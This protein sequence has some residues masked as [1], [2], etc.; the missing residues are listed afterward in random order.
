MPVAG[1]DEFRFR[2]EHDGIPAGCCSQH[3]RNARD[4]ARTPDARGWRHLPVGRFV[5][6]GYCW[7]FYLDGTVVPSMVRSD[8]QSP[9][10]VSHLQELEP[11]SV[12]RRTAM[13]LVIDRN[14]L[15][16]EI[17]ELAAISD[18]VAPA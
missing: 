10:E 17:E 8:R 11:A 12:G 2:G 9:G 1:Y 5:V 15:A 7:R 14:R 4:G 3:G 6:P 18:A 13:K 16:A